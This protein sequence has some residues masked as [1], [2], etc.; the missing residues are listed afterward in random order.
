MQLLYNQN[1]ENP[2]FDGTISAM[3]WR[4]AKL[5][6][7]RTYQFTYDNINRLTSAQ[8]TGIY[9]EKYSTAYSYDSNGNILTLRRK[10]QFTDLNYG[11]IDQLSYTYH[12]NQLI[13][14][15]D[16]SGNSLGFS[17]QVKH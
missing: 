5:S 17:R 8:Y 2:L 11:V 9:G 16:N 1:S 12:G 3:Q 4:S 15:N 6:V 13:G 10:G 7:P 14:V